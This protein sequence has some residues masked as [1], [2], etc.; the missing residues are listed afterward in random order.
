MTHEYR[1]QR[2]DPHRRCRTNVR[3]RGSRWRAPFARVNLR[4]EPPNRLDGGRAHPVDLADDAVPHA[5]IGADEEARGQHAHSPGAGRVLA[6]I[7]EHRQ[8]EGGALQEVARPGCPTRRSSPRGWRM[9]ARRNAASAAASRASPRGR[10]RTTS[11]RSSR[12]RPCRDSRRARA[13]LRRGR[14]GRA[15]ASCTSFQGTKRP[16]S[17]CPPGM[18][19]AHT[20]ASP[21]SSESASLGACRRKCRLER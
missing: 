15:A 3:P 1:R 21:A 10:A 14:G 9:A 17:A 7:E 6:R 12:A 2:V 5:A 16:S 20:H 8:V 19:R 4:E 11:P 18:A 13:A